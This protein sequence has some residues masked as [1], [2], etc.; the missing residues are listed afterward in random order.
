MFY[1]AKLQLVLRER[2]KNLQDSE[3]EDLLPWKHMLYQSW[4]GS[5]SFAHNQ[6][7]SC[8]RIWRK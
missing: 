1:V 7:N 6:D 3:H 4:V 2:F 5:K 8:I